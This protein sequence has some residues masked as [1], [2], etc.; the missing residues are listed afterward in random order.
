MSVAMAFKID[1]ARLRAAPPRAGQ[2]LAVESSI[3][4]S[5]RASFARGSAIFDEANALEEKGRVFVLADKKVLA[6]YGG[7]L[8]IRR[9]RIFPAPAD[10]HFKTLGGVSRFLSFLDRN[11]A[12]RSDTLLVIGGGIMQDAGGFAATIYKRGMNWVFV[13]TTL[14]SMCD[15]CIG[16]K[17]GINFGSAKNQLGVFAK[18]SAV[19]IDP[20]LLSTLEHR[21]VR[22]GLGEVLKMCVIGGEKAMQLYAKD[23][24]SALACDLDALQRLI[25]LSL[26]IKKAVV[27][28]DELERGIRKALNYGHTVGHALEALSNFRVS[29]GEGV[30]LGMAAANALAVSQGFLSSKCATELESCCVELC[31]GARLPR[32]RPEAL[33]GLL[34]KDKKNIGGKVFFV[35]PRAPGDMIYMQRNPGMPLW[36]HIIDTLERLAA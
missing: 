6:L 36:R 32:L 27:E 8:K 31:A 9:E 7:S 16:A 3:G 29:H 13:P 21:H 20:R 28:E 24:H 25:A 19:L 30:V 18:P 4:P 23:V 5:Y 26:S 35:A 10:E 33:A 14:L 15:S 22:S 2:P 12:T 1:G 11:G 34:L 17:T